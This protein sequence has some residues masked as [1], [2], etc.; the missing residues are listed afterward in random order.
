MEIL[1]EGGPAFAEPPSHKPPSHKA[2]A[3]QGLRRAR[4]Y[5]VAGCGKFLFSLRGVGPPRTRGCSFHE[6]NG[7]GQKSEV[8]SQRSEVGSR[9]GEWSRREPSD[10][11]E[12]RRVSEAGPSE[13][14]RRD[15]VAADRR[16]SREVAVQ[17]RDGEASVRGFRPIGSRGCL[18]PIERRSRAIDAPTL[19]I[20]S[21]T[22]ANRARVALRVVSLD[23]RRLLV[24]K[25]EG[26]TS[27]V[28]SKK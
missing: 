18:I 6:A 10:M 1:R 21:R 19:G 22:V 14:I 9:N 26:F 15:G 25:L 5:G 16:R 27:K 8:R 4:A 24:V 3:S 17:S 28:E 23:R 13:S 12:A 7:G 2:T 20:A 11:D